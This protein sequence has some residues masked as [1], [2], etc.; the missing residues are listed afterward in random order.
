MDL[1][2]QTQQLL[3]Q[4][5]AVDAPPIW[6]QPLDELRFNFN[7]MVVDLQTPGPALKR[8]EDRHIAGPHGAIPVRIY[9]PDDAAEGPLPIFM[10]FHGSGFV[11]LG[12]DSHDNVCREFSQGAGCIVVAVDYR[13][14]PENKFPKP[15]DDAWA[16]TLWAVENSAELGA[17]NGCI[18]VGGDSAGGC[19]AAVV[20]QRAVREG[21]PKIAFQ[22]LVYPVTD[23]S[24]DTDSYRRFADGYSLTADMMRWFVR[25]YL[26]S[27]GEKTD[28]TAAPIRA[29]DLTGLAPALVIAA[30]HDPLL[31]EGIAYSEK[32]RAAGVRVTHSEYAGQIHGFW[33]F[34]DRI[35]A[36][37]EARAEACAALR[38][39]FG[40]TE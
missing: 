12:L 24:D 26:N 36:S 33:N 35:D 22:L 1:D 13:K 7:E 15:T 19:L 38:K 11:V 40:S 25:C 30:S 21:A 23:M 32:M 39:A 5:N 34:T 8:V 3:D 31:D 2:P 37:H 17:D 6:D 18:A 28:P 29:A 20:A 16:A 10:H 4:M 27:D 9:W 14:S